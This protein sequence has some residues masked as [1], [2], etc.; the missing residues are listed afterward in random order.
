[1]PPPR[2][3]LPSRHLSRRC[4]YASQV[5]H[6][7]MSGESYRVSGSHLLALGGFG[8]DCRVMRSWQLPPKARVRT[9]C[10]D[11]TRSYKSVNVRCQV[12]ESGNLPVRVTGKDGK[13]YRCSGSPRGQKSRSRRPD[14]GLHGVPAPAA[15]EDAPGATTG[16]RAIP[17]TP[18]DG[19]RGQVVRRTGVRA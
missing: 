14:S 2:R 15:C 19:R 11:E 18:P 8:L 4:I 10:C 6:L 13:S 17:Y 3:G 7:G 1:M 16:T 9:L 12:T 5:L